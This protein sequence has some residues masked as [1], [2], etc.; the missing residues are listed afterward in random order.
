MLGLLV[1][2]AQEGLETLERMVTMEQF[3]LS[4]IQFPEASPG[5]PTERLFSFLRDR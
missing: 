1:L 4:Q 3:S 2:V 5:P